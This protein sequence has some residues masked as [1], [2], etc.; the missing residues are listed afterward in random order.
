M[1]DF[2]GSYQLS[3]RS[4]NHMESEIVILSCLSFRHEYLIISHNISWYLSIYPYSPIH[5]NR[6]MSTHT[7]YV[8][9]FGPPL[10]KCGAEDSTGYGGHRLSPC[11]KPSSIL[12]LSFSSSLA[13]PFQPQHMIWHCEAWWFCDFCRDVDIW[14]YDV[15]IW[16]DM[17]I[18]FAVIDL[19]L[20]AVASTILAPGLRRAVAL[21]RLWGRCPHGGRW[22]AKRLCKPNAEKTFEH[23]NVI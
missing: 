12:S 11:H 22:T 6:D 13:D 18:F 21:R 15:D 8:V 3:T 17:M 9:C 14:L 7:D 23:I 16:C 20:S 10:A 19:F 2:E 5:S 1:N 4:G